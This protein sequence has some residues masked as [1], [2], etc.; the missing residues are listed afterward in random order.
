MTQP[1]ESDILGRPNH[2]AR[3]ELPEQRPVIDVTACAGPAGA[4]VWLNLYGERGAFLTI[5]QTLALARALQEEARCTKDWVDACL[6]AE[7]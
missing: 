3:I 7:R 5:D 1:G 4:H 6:E 2:Y